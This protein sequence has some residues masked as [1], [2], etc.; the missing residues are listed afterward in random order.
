M[1]VSLPL[2]WMLLQAPQALSLRDCIRYALNHAPALQNAYLD[3]LLARQKIAEVRAAGLPQITGSASFRYFIEIPTSLVPSEFITGGRI[4]GE[5]FPVQFGVPYNL[6]LSLTG[7]QLI[8]D[9]TYF[10]GLR[11]AQAI[12]ELT[13]RSYQRTRAETVVAVQKAYY[14]ALISQERLRLLAQS[15][16]QLELLNR[17]TEGLYRQGFT[18]KLD[19][20]R[21]QVALANLQTEYERAK[22]LT[23][24]AYLTLKLQMGMPL[25]TPIA[26]T[27][28]LAPEELLQSLPD[29]LDLASFDPTRRWEY[30]VLSA[31]RRALELNMRRYQV[32]Y[33][34][35]LSFV[36]TL[37]AQA[38][39]R[40]FDFLDT[41]QRWFPIAFIGLQLQVPLFD[42]LRRASQIQQA[43]LELQK[44][45]ND[46][47]QLRQALTLEA[48]NARRQ[49]LSSLKALQI[50][51][52]NLA[53]A[54]EVLR[55]T[56]RKQ[57]LGVGSN[58]ELLQAQ[59]SYEQ[60]QTNYTTAL[61][62]TYL[63][64][65]DWQKAI[66]TLPME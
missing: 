65:V 10:V 16:D 26:L 28:T 11:A 15:V 57:E 19:V 22:E 58:L 66:G 33:L 47:F 7:V 23:A 20:Q 32:S 6:D 14:T 30:Q 29:T 9:G 64:Y 48:E 4:R 18:E 42:G 17:Q 31:Q 55:T 51:K 43:R 62:E 54:E 3:Y 41:R 46:L 44:N 2:L 5:F 53:L 63:A 49:F 27:D 45:Q 13:R 1:Y 21:L 40:K 25:E 52:R 37:T 56:R 39:R 38:Q 34:P 8:F 61:L 36:G 59:T 50:Q 35:T 24:L 60:A 12:K